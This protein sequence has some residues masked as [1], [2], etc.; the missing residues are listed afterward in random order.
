MGGQCHIPRNVAQRKMCSKHHAE[1][2]HSNDWGLITVPRGR[3]GGRPAPKDIDERSWKLL[4]SVRLD[5]VY[6][7]T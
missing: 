2:E 4:L 1:E 5:R 6:Q 7:R 3:G